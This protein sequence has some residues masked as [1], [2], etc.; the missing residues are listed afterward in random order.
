MSYFFFKGI[1]FSIDNYK[2]IK[3]KLKKGGYL[4][5]PA[6]SSLAKIYKL[7]KYYYSLRNA[8]VVIPDSGFFCILVKIF[9][10]KKIRRLSGF[11][12]LKQFLNDKFNYNKKILLVDPT[13]KES[14]LNTLLLKKNFFKKTLSYVAPIYSKN[15]HDQNLIR[16]IKKNNPD[17]ILVNLGGEVQEVLANYLLKN[18]N[19]SIQIICTGAAIAFMTGSQVKINDFIDR[20]YLGWLVRLLT[21]KNFIKKRLLSSLSLVKLF[22]K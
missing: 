22:F 19:P 12:Y 20:F 17:I 1:R 13:I 6:A 7:N 11:F 18:I 2:V 8:K 4:V 10:N 16:I 5:A 15:I 3:L 9:K 21:S 14:K